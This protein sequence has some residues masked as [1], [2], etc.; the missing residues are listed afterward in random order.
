MNMNLL[1]IIVLLLFACSTEP[2]KIEYGSDQ[3]HFCKMT[4]VD[5]QHASQMVNQ[6]G[7][8]FKYDAIE[9]MINDLAFKKEQNMSSILVCDYTQPGTLVQAS[10]ATYLISKEIKSPMGAFLSAGTDESSMKALKE[11]HGGSLYTWN[12]IK[13]EIKKNN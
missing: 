1:S 9:C 4:I 3:C 5:R 2:E 8:Q 7:K 6:K 11:K 12:E 10:T 13:D